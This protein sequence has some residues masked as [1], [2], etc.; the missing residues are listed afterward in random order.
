MTLRIGF[1]KP[2]TG[3]PL[4]SWI[5][6][7]YEGV[8]FSHV[9]MRWQTKSGLWLCYHASGIQVNFL[10]PAAFE[11]HIHIVEEFEYEVSEEH[12]HVFRDYCIEQ[13]GKPYALKELFGIVLADLFQLK[14]NPLSGGEWIQYCAELLARSWEKLTGQQL[15]FDKDR[16]KLKQVHSL[17]KNAC[18]KVV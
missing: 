11:H 5:I 9:Y 1:S 13:C 15:D 18:K 7:L 4:L 14:K 17:V 2:K 12:A 3:F 16:V 10:G 6:R 8:P